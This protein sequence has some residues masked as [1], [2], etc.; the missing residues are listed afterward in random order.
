MKSFSKKANISTQLMLFILTR[1]YA[2]RRYLLYKKTIPKTTKAN[3]C[4]KRGRVEALVR[5]PEALMT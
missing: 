4:K 5:E 2:F 3:N 1:D